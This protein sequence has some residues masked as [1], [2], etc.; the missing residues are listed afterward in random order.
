MRHRRSIEQ[1]LQ[2][3]PAP[4]R[5]ESGGAARGAPAPHEGTRA[6]ERAR[7][8]TC[9]ST[10]TSSWQR[11]RAAGALLRVRPLQYRTDR[12]CINMTASPSRRLSTPLVVPLLT[13]V[14]SQASLASASQVG[15][16]GGF[17][18]PVAG[19]VN[20]AC[21]GDSI[22]FGAH[23][24]GGN[25]TYPG[26][27]QIMLDKKYPGKYCVTNLGQSGA[28]MQRPPNGD[29]PWWRTSKY[30]QW[31]DP[32]NAKLW[33]M[34][35]IMLGTNDAKDACPAE[36][37][38]ASAGCGN[39]SFCESN[40]PG[41][42]CNWPHAGQT[43]WVQDCTDGV[44]CPFEKTYG[45]MIALARTLGKQPAGPAIWTA[46]PPPLC[47]HAL[48]VALLPHAISVR[49]SP[50]HLAHP[51]AWSYSCRAC[52]LRIAGGSPGSPAK[53]YGMN[54]TV[55]ND[56]LPVVI[57]KINLANKLPHPAIDVL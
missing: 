31:T 54:Q 53:P 3:P 44:S 42:C 43:T 18:G 57:S 48:A 35:V 46:I 34:V 25:T 21:V 40:R 2:A 20:V 37:C 12:V 30:K 39:A 45:E 17:A 7:A 9:I 5:H 19:K 16:C 50:G 4:L 33:D 10:P 36:G 55:I 56:I 28:T 23:S 14:L 11:R 32:A 49:L 8:R 38:P 29:A 6:I 22:T 47:V 15:E 41:S 13:L 27:L 24:R 51:D 52:E 1:A 26:Q